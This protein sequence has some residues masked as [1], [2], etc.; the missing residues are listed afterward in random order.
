MIED[1]NAFDDGVCIK[2][3]VCII[4]A[5]AAGIALAMEFLGTHFRVV[6]LESGGLDNE[7]QM[8]EL[9]KAE[10]TG[11]PH[12]GIEKGRFRAFGGTTIAWGGQTIRL[13]AFDLQT[14]SW[15][16]NSGWPITLQE[17]EPYYDRAEQVLKLGPSIPYEKLCIRS[18]IDP[19]AFDPAK[20][21]MDCSR[22]SPRTSPY[23]CMLR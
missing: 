20:L 1:F 15:V 5:G 7:S 17:L 9:N 19:P 10:V 12:Q 6:V 13:G 3:D 22:W 21:R 2:G 18:G 4:G 14:R 16:P 8:Q 11:L 23:S